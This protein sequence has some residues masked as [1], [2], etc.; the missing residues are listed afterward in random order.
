MC[1]AIFSEYGAAIPSKAV[2][3]R[4][5][6]LNRDGAGYAYLTERGTWYVRKGFMTWN[7]FYESFSAQE[8]KKEHTVLVH[9]R[10]GTSGPRKDGQYH[11]GCTHPFPSSDSVEDL[12]ALEYE[13]ESIVCHNGVVGK[14]T[15]KLSDTQEFVAKYVAPLYPLIEDQRIRTILH[16]V[17]DA[18]NFGQGSRWFLSLGDNYYLL[19]G[20]VKDKDTGIWYSKNQYTAA[21]YQEQLRK[22]KEAAEKKKTATTTS[23]YSTKKGLVISY[24]PKV[25]FESIL[26]NTKQVSW[27][28]VKKIVDKKEVKE[29]KNTTTTLEV[30]KKGNV[31]NFLK[32][33]EI[34]EIYNVNNGLIGIVDNHGNVVWEDEDV[35]TTPFTTTTTKRKEQEDYQRKCTHCGLYLRESELISGGCPTCGAM[36]AI[37]LYDTDDED[38]VQGVDIS[39]CP[40]CAAELTGFM[41]NDNVCPWCYADI[42]EKVE[43]PYCH[44]DRLY[45]NIDSNNG[46]THECLNCGA[47]WINDI[48]G[49]D[50]V[51][52]VNTYKREEYNSRMQRAMKGLVD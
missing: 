42:T 39:K 3:E 16:E 8:F 7:K 21:H 28:E 45:M 41:M 30:D 36:T 34:I 47:R 31:E 6:D 1:I 48:A 40:E 26:T 10:A 18:G 29:V 46:A 32:E 11:P 27:E 15:T 52:D 43:C 17:L 35:S 19:G 37:I 51:V 50:G 12:M 5:W 4:G 49:I 38:E 2:M 23:T 22:R 24:L 13:S 20:W 44:E 14:G 9:F 33:G 25:K